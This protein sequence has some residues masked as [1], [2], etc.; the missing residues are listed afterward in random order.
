MCAD[1]PEF[2]GNY[3]AFGKVIEGMDIAAKISNLPV[4]T[5]TDDTTG[6]SKPSEMPQDKPV[7]TTMTVD[8]F[9]VKYND[10]VLVKTY[11]IMPL[12]YKYYG[13]SQ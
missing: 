5:T 10:P 3:T 6:E 8:T 2:D 4:T 1:E 12:L 7:I 9:G 13:I 11:D